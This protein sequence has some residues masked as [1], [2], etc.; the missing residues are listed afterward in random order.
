MSKSSQLHPFMKLRCEL[1]A[2]NRCGHASYRVD[3]PC[4]HWTDRFQFCISARKRSTKNSVTLSRTDSA[5]PLI[6][7]KL[8]D[9]LSLHVCARTCTDWTFTGAWKNLSPDLRGKRKV[10]HID[11]YNKLRIIFLQLHEMF[12]VFTAM[13]FNQ[14]EQIWARKLPGGFKN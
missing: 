8:S 9:S 4:S 2:S 3:T 6:G 1:A 13:V 5:Y 11:M 14:R 7:N 10:R 12:A